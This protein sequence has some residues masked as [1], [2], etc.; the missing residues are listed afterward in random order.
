MTIQVYVRNG[1]HSE[2]PILILSGN[3]TNAPNQRAEVLPGYALTVD[4]EQTDI[5]VIRTSPAV[6]PVTSPQVE[7]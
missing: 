5:L 3:G 6:D 2:L 4:L 7:A 1:E